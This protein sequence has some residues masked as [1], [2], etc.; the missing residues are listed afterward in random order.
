MCP[1]PE[2]RHMYEWQSHTFASKSEV[3]AAAATYRQ[4]HETYESPLTAPVST[5]IGERLWN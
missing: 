2:S 5:G 1:P 3:T 4:P